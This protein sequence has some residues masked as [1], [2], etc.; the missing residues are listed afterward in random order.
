MSYIPWI[1]PSY[2]AVF[3]TMK[4]LNTSLAFGST[5]YACSRWLLPSRET[6]EDRL[7]RETRQR[8]EMME[9]KIDQIWAL[10]LQPADNEEQKS[11]WLS[12]I[13]ILPTYCDGGIPQNSQSA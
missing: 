4:F 11:Q 12:D 10:Q 9:K 6:P 1:A 5:M 13:V 7:A 3:S 2:L 8:L